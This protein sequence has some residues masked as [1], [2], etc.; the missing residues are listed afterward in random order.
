[1]KIIVYQWDKTATKE[2]ICSDCARFLLFFLLSIKC[3]TAKQITF[4]PIHV[5]HYKEFE[6]ENI[7]LSNENKSFCYMSSYKKIG[8]D[9]STQSEKE[10]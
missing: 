4:S 10:K 6:K 2:Q 1:M 3:W 7:W 5:F 8:N 9:K